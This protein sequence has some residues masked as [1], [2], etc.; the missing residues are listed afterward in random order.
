VWVL[1]RLTAASHKYT[2]GHVTVLGG[3]E[4]TGAARLAADAARHGG[5]GLVTI[6]ASGGAD[7]YRMGAAG[8]IVSEAKLAELLEDKRRRVWVCGPG[9]GQTAAAAALPALIAAGREIV[10]DADALSAC[11]GAPERLR[12]VSVITP[13]AGEFRKVFG[14]VGPDKVAAVRAAAARIGAVV[15][16]KGADTVIA[17]PDRRVAIN[18]SAPPW[19]ATAGSG[20]VLSGLVGSLMGQ[21]MAPF[22][23]ACAAVWLHGRAGARLGAG[24]LA[25]DL[26]G[27]LEG[28]MAEVAD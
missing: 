5:A 24:L 8:V 23:A 6:A 9:L 28:A 20:D 11:A 25:E 7:V 2:R 19:L 14:E 13:H 21:G 27:A 17:A 18:A 1:P 16:L 3:A 26:P 12:G 10:A 15:V 22:E 4:M